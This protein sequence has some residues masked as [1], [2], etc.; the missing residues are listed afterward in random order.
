MG[1]RGQVDSG[2]STE[3]SLQCQAEERHFILEAQGSQER[4]YE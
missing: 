3:V 2:Q 1:E 4:F